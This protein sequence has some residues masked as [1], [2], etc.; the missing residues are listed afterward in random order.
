MGGRVGAHH[1]PSRQRLLNGSGCAGGLIAT[2]GTI[3]QGRKL[4]D[5]YF[6]LFFL[7]YISLFFRMPTST[8]LN[9]IKRNL[10]GGLSLTA[11]TLSYTHSHRSYPIDRNDN[12]ESL[13]SIYCNLSLK[14]GFHLCVN[15]VISL[16]CCK[17][18]HHVAV[19]ISKCP[20]P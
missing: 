1:R 12:Q 9:Y 13:M 8:L 6:T 11:S 10:K 14:W 7:Y 3:F 17:D 20:V 4:T 2:Q 15:L 19:I 5:Y 16:Q 18:L